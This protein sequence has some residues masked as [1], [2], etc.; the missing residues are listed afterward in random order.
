MTSASRDTRAIRFLQAAGLLLLPALLQAAGK[1][2]NDCCQLPCVEA[3]IRYALQ[4]QKWYRTQARVPNL[5]PEQYEAAEKKKAEELSKERAKDAGRL[6]ACKWNLPDPKTDPVAVRQWSAARWS[7][8]SDDKGNI[9]YNFT[10][11]TDKDKCTLSEKQI[12]MYHEIAPCEG[13]A[14]AAEKHERYHVDSCDKRKGRKA[15]MAD[16][17]KDEIDAY[18][19]ELKQLNAL[20][21]SLEKICNKSTC[22][23]KDTGVVKRQLEKELEELKQQ[24]AKRGGKGR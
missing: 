12:S 24:L 5:T 2:C 3:E 22:K 13:M 19:E 11:K 20:R 18:D 15:T 10:M 17:V 1:P 14:D 23:D 8:T 21:E 6:T 9:S 7:I 16:V 4:M